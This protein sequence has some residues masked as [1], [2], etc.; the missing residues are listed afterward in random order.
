MKNIFKYLFLLLFCSFVLVGCRSDNGENPSGGGE[1]PPAVEI[2]YEISLDYESLDLEVGEQKIL[3]ATLLANGK[4]SKDDITWTTSNE[5][6]A[7]VIDGKITAIGD[8]EAVI[9]AS[10]HNVSATANITVTTPDPF[11]VLSATFMEVKMGKTAQ[12]DA[13]LTVGELQ[14]IS[15]SSDNTSVVTVSQTGLIS[16][17]AEG[18][19]II[20]VTTGEGKIATCKISVI[21]DYELIFPEIE[22]KDVFIGDVIDLSKIIDVSAPNEQ[23]TALVLTNQNNLFSNLTFKLSKIYLSIAGD[24]NISLIPKSFLLI[25]ATIFSLIMYSIKFK[26]KPTENKESSI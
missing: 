10:A 21:M 20:T 5:S 2:T 22:N 3:V 4:K 9:T 13:W 18:E 25:Y 12:L 19:A 17:L 16:A 24:R 14:N 15:Y 1:N 8:G 11:L 26:F 6:V 23:G 7:S